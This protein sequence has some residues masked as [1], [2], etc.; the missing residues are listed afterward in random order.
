MLED[1]LNRGGYKVSDIVKA[2]I[3]SVVEGIT[4]FLPISSTGHLILVNHWIEFQG[5]FAK[6]FDVII[7]FGA[8]L[9][10]LVLYWNKLYPFSKRKNM[11]EKRETMKLW[12]KVV[13]ALMPAVVLGLL[14]ADFI[15]EKLF[16]PIVVATTLTIGGI[17]IILL[18]RRKKNP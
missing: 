11:R 1:I 14:F 15:E 3:L 10:V 9:S 18:E 2:I 5:S 6:S 16:N 17:A 8:I 7:Q 13:V 12:Y 4:E